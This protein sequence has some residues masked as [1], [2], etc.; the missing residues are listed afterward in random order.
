MQMMIGGTRTDSLDGIWIEVKNPATGELVDRVPSGS[1][2]DVNRAVEAADA[3]Y[4][5][6][7]QKTARE[8]GMTLFRASEIVRD[9][10]RDIASLL[11]TEQGKPLKESIDEVRGFASILEFYAG[12]SAQQTGEMA[13]LGSAGDCLITREPLGVCGAIIPWNMPVIIMGWKVGPALLAG[14]TLVLKPA[15]ATPLANLTL[16]GILEES[17]LPRESS[18]SLPGRGNGWGAL[19]RHPLGT[20]NLVYRQQRDR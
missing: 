5:G 3:A 9:R 7:K 11:T 6:W 2:E 20:K 17:G 13:R 12:I 14:N 16:A 15:S 10:H 18:M 19:V 8:R 1:S 4:A